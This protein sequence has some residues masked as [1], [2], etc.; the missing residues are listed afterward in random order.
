MQYGGTL[1]D[2]SQPTLPFEETGTGA[3]SCATYSSAN[4]ELT[5]CAASAIV[6]SSNVAVFATRTNPSVIYALP[7]EYGGNAP[8]DTEKNFYVDFRLRNT[9]SVATTLDDYGAAIQDSNGNFLFRL[10]R[11]SG[12]ALQPNDHTPPFNMRGY[13]TEDRLVGGAATTF[14]S[15]VQV[16]AGGTWQDVTGPGSFATF[17]V[18]PRPPLQDGMLVKRPRSVVSTDATVYRYQ[19]G[20]KW[21]G[22]QVAFDGLYPG[23]SQEFYV[24]P[25]ATINALGNPTTPSFDSTVP[26][27]LGRNLLYKLGIDVYIIEPDPANPSPPLRSRRFQN[28]AAFNSYGY[29]N[30]VLTTEPIPVT[31]A[32]ASWIQDREPV[33]IGQ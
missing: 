21:V 10:A 14:R 12:L 26:V 20:K 6:V 9:G 8:E 3:F 13:I 5:S 16:K 28:Q 7:N 18:N 29:A 24:Y 19:S 27:I 31:A 4:T 11:G 30:A 15:Q 25:S 23:W 33:P 1:A 17:T 2:A 22:T 32:Q